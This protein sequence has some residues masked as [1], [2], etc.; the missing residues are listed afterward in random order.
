MADS[1][2]D[3]QAR[4]TVAVRVRPKLASPLNPLQQ[5]ERYEEVVCLPTSDRSLRLTHCR[6][7]KGSGGLHFAYDHVLDSEA[8]QEDVYEAAAVDGVDGVLAGTNASILT[9]GQTGSGKTFT[10]LGKTAAAAA[11]A[12]TAADA[13]HVVGPDTGLLLRAIQDMLHFAE[14]VRVK[15]ERHVVLGITAT[16]IY[17]DEIRDLLREGAAG[18]PL[19]PIMTRD[20]LHLPHLTHAPLNSLADA[21][22]VCD[23]AASRRVQR[24]TSANDTSSRSHALFTI[25]VFQTPIS[26][27]CPLP[28]SLAECC[29]L[30]EAQ[31]AAVTAVD[32]GAAPQQRGGS[33]PLRCACFEGAANPLL[34]TRDVPVMFSSLTVADLAGSEKAKHADVRGTGF[35]ELRRIN[36]S[37][38][39]LGNVVHHLYRGSAHVPYRDSKLTMM[40]RDTFAA[41]RARIV[42]VANVSP[43]AVTCEETLSSLYF[44][45]KM[46]GL[47]ASDTGSTTPQQAA[48]QAAYLGSLREHDALLAEARIFQV[49]QEHATGLLPR[50]AA[51]TD[52][53]PLFQLPYHTPL[54]QGPDKASRL[55]LLCGRLRERLAHEEESP[56]AKLQRFAETRCRELCRDR[57][58]L[59]SQRRADVH[60]ATAAEEA[61]GA[62]LR[63]D[64]A[65]A[66]G[67]MSEQLRTAKAAAM[68]AVETRQAA[69][70]QRKARAAELQRVK[71][72]ESSLATVEAATAD[73]A[74]LEED[75]DGGQRDV[76]AKAEE[77][78]QL[79]LTLVGLLA[80]GGFPSSTPSP[81]PTARA[82]SGTRVSGA[83][84]VTAS[85]SRS[86]TAATPTAA[87]SSSA[88]STS[89]SVETWVRAAVLAMAGNAVVQSTRRQ[90][91]PRQPSPGARPARVLADVTNA[92]GGRTALPKYWSVCRQLEAS[93]GG[94]AGHSATAAGVSATAAAPHTTTTTR[95]P[96]S[97]FDDPALLTKV[98]AY[99]DMGASL[100]KLDGDG[101][102]HSRW[103]YLSQ[104]GDRLMLCWDDSRRGPGLTGGGHVY[105]DAV[106]N[107]T[108][109]RSSPRFRKL[110]ALKGGS[111][112]DVDDVYT[113]FT[114]AYRTRAS[115]RELKFVD[116]ICADRVELETWVVGLAHWAGVSPRFEDAWQ[117]DEC[118]AEAAVGG[119]A[120]DGAGELSPEEAAVSRTWHIPAGALQRARDEIEARRVRHP[121]GRLRLSPSEMRDLT[122][123]DVFRAS[124]LWLHFQ[125][126][127]SIVNS[128]KHLRCYVALPRSG[129]TAS[130]QSPEA[131]ST[132]A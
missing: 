51:L 65:D 12:A 129:E 130:P 105:L 28:P 71:D 5:S 79:R 126:Q 63:A 94:A 97:S 95:R 99:M 109:G 34:G 131:P 68:A 37:L 78:A 67:V 115:G 72:A 39:A 82:A 88:P 118:E 116:V 85:R 30:R 40:L 4:V 3:G 17:M 111:C 110:A 43:T 101:R 38:T 75:E 2:D 19:Q 113:S 117:P 60:A 46:K 61:A 108:L 121:S 122:G 96:V 73:A 52:R 83:R 120:A 132:A 33:R 31:Y 58:K 1:T 24:A 6:A 49:Q 69:A 89:R 125:Q 10:V 103:F 127:G 29:A 74:S 76:L 87:A 77:L 98:T 50:V 35:D 13:T 36:A 104:K 9:Y 48:L 14:R 15:G 92:V 86:G 128:T 44:A 20:A 106:A 21:C 32:G 114:V 26:A 93:A 7:G 11:A 16:E 23:R 54:P 22:L 64:V 107:V 112:G 102:P 18:R 57:L 42:L 27:S 41:P 66:E 59:Y 119:G 45:D 56:E 70:Q 100:L 55:R 124:A 90:R 53:H 84:T 47:P 81:S 80:S 62:Q 123:L 25:E 8:T 91:Q